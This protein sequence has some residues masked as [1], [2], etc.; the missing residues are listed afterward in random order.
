LGDSHGE[1]SKSS[2]R[3]SRS[4]AGGVCSP[5]QNGL[6]AGA[7]GRQHAEAGDDDAAR[8][9][10][11][12]HAVE[13]TSSRRRRRPGGGPAVALA[14]SRL[15]AVALVFPG[16]GSQRPAMGLPWRDAAGWSLVEQAS[17]AVGRDLGRL[18]VEA[19]AEE[20][21][22]TREAQVST[23]LASCWC[24]RALPPL[25]VAVVAGHSLGEITALV[26]AGVLSPEDG[27]HVVSQRG[28]AMQHAADAAPGT[29]A[30]VLG[31]ADAA[32]ERVLEGVD[33]CWPANTTRPSPVVV[34][35]R[36]RGLRSRRRPKEAGGSDG[37]LPTAG[38]RRFHTPLME[39]ARPRWDR[40]LRG[41]SGST[42]RAGAV[43]RTL[44]NLRGDWPDV[45]SASS[46]PL[47]AGAGWRR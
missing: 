27:L 35:G 24:T 20:L 34:A 47:S 23:F 32:V 37:L 3:R 38:R 17:Q 29:M 21:R 18:L 11:G 46:P 26:A 6:E 43:R 8:G 31:L 14:G 44:R 9:G 19:D 10:A 16:Q 13:R 42:G 2:T 12:L 15:V 4:S 5:F 33:D 41:A 39:P 28:S 22:A 40:A 25:D 36:R 45:L 30:A 7:G 1:G